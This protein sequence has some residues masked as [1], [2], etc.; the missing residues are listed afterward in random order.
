MKFLVYLGYGLMMAAVSMPAAA[1]PGGSDGDAGYSVQIPPP[2]PLA[3]R[4]TDRPARQLGPGEIE[5]S[6]MSVDERRQLRRD[7]ENAGRV[8]YRSAPHA[9][10][11][12]PRSGRR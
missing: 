6:R 9:R 1:G 8:I 2:Q 3:P 4:E 7:I 5:R 11:G 12:G 10:R